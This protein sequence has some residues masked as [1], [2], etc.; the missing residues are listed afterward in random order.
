MIFVFEMYEPRSG[1]DKILFYYYYF[2][3]YS[4]QF[5]QHEFEKICFDFNIL[6]Y[7]SVIDICNTTFHNN[8]VIYTIRYG[9]V[10]FPTRRGKKKE[11]I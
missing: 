7:K 8:W 5:L 10:R 4:F 1:S 6:V 11:W 2:P 3:Y 9:Y